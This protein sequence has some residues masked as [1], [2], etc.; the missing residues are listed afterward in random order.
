MNPLKLALE[1]QDFVQAISLIENKD[2]DLSFDNY[3]PIRYALRN[4]L[5][6]IIRLLLGDTRTNLH[7]VPSILIA[8]DYGQQEALEILL[9]DGRFN[10]LS[11]GNFLIIE[12][13]C[14]NYYPEIAEM[15]L[16]DGRFNS[17][18]NYGSAMN[19]ACE[20]GFTKIVKLLIDKANVLDRNI[21]LASEYGHTEIVRIL[22]EDG[23]VN[24]STDD[25]IAIRCSSKYGYRKITSMLCDDKRVDRKA[26]LR[27]AIR[28]NQTF[29]IKMI[30]W[31]ILGKLLMDCEAIQGE[32]N[33]PK[34][35]IRIIERNMIMIEMSERRDS[36]C[37]PKIDI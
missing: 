33:I 25:N 12:Q 15:L 13:A 1:N 8:C 6:Q 32:L 36:R 29:I 27:E 4:G 5:I 26:G 37:L 19:I 35:I 11:S 10:P 23:R 9:R 16:A 17:N 20:Y 14:K 30:I 28:R 31:K 2:T 3:F 18:W 34:D 24:P 7:K 22:L 21:W